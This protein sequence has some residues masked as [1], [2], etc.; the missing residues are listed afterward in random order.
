MNPLLPFEWVLATRFMREGFLQTLFIIAGVALGVSVIVFMSAL[1]GGLQ[2]S[3]FKTLLDY[4]PQIVISPPDE[5]PRVLR[6]GG[7]AE[8]ATLLQPRAQ[9]PRS[10]DQW[11]KLRDNTLA[12]P[13]VLVVAPVVEGAAFILRGD[14]ISGVGVRGIE[15]DSYLRLIAL[16]EKIIA[17]SAG[18]ASTDI[19]IGAKLAKDLGVWTGDKLT[20]QAASGAS[21]VLFVSG[22]F[23]FGNQAQNTGI[24]YMALRTAQSL[25]GLPGGATSL[26]VKVTEPFEAETLAAQIAAQPGIKVESWIKTNAEFFKALSGQTLTFFMIRLFVGITAA[27]GIASVLVVSVVQKSKEIGIL[28]ATGTTRGQILRVFLL[29]GAIFGF[30]GSLLGSLMGWGFLSAWRGYARNDEGV[31][32]FTLDVGPMLF[33]YVAIGATLVGTLSALFPA[34]RAARLDPAVAIRG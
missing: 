32:F 6:R 18:I 27:L 8:M 12:I 11:Q 31:P 15:P 4:Q 16:K 20:I 13:G 2:G 34:Q 28:R 30:L 7:D 29:Q 25:L 26:Q 21:S 10:I 9:R 14:A 17:G 1:L 22:I 23:D 5:A 3:I 24:V 33:I 19:V